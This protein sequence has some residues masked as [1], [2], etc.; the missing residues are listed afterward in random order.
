SRRISIADLSQF[1]S[2]FGESDSGRN[3]S[4]GIECGI[5]RAY[6]LIIANDGFRIKASRKSHKL[7]LLYLRANF[8][9]RH[10]R[11]GRRLVLKRPELGPIDS[12]PFAEIGVCRY[13]LDQP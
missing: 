2:L 13:R 10:G 11:F 1:E 3:L 12:S 7:K 8:A 4:T 9:L 5:K 6:Q